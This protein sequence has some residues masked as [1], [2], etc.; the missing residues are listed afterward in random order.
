MKSVLTSFRSCSLVPALFA[1]AIGLCTSAPPARAAEV[2]AA[3]QQGLAGVKR[4]L[5]LGDSITHAGKYIAYVETYLRT[6]DPDFAI[7]FINMGLASE[8]VSGLSE[9]DHAGGK[10]PR[11][12]VHERLERALA[13][14][15]PDLVVAC[16]GMNCGIYHPF[17]D[18][19][20]QKY[21]A[22]M[23]LL[24][25]R[26]ADVGARVLHLT[27]PVFD[28]EPI[29]ARV[30]PA[31]RTDYRTPYEGYDDVLARYSD[32]LL[33]KRSKSAA[34]DGWDVVDVHGPMLRFLKEH[35]ASDPKYCLAGD[36][37]HPNDIGQWIIA[38]A[39]LLHWGAPAAE[40]AR[41]EDGDKVIAQKPNG[42][43]M[44]KLI[45]ERQALLHDAW[46]TKTGH[47][48]PGVKAG[49]PMEEAQAKAKEIDAKIAALKP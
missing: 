45:A 47:K 37:V 26:S 14:V 19:R 15:K 41:A 18:E 42:P 21:Q 44:L 39:L 43:A 31:G 22:G 7:E 17:S 9:E 2:P 38:R 36:G 49:L 29:R 24:R 8:T 34:A 13:A 11:P 3:G 33:S 16:Y 23:E 10:F 4:V 20:F 35:R 48:R 28:P 46:L 1:F 27:P 32:W 6:H 12:T 30:L 5:F 25:K 40:I